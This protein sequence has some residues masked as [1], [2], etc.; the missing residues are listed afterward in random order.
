MSAPKGHG[1]ADDAADYEDLPEPEEPG[2][3]AGGIAD[4]ANLFEDLVEETSDGGRSLESNWLYQVDGHVFGPV[5]PK[6][7]L[8]ML[9][10]GELTADSPIAV[11]DEEFSPLRRFGVFRA[12]LPKVQAHQQELENQKK[13]ERAET[14]RRVMRRIGMVVA[15]VLVLAG[16]S[17]GLMEYI[18]W[19]REQAA[20][21]EKKKKEEALKK[22]IDDLYAS[23]TIE[24]PLMPL[25]EETDEPRGKGKGK[26][27]RR[28]RRGK[29]A[30]ASFGTGELKREEIMGGVAKVF[31]GF[32]R[33]IVEQM[34]REPDTVPE[35]IVLTFVIGNDGKARDVSITD[36]IL[37]RSPLKGCMAGQ[38]GRTRWRAFKGEVRNVEYPIT[39]GRR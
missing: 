3:K 38:L 9:Y 5:K 29:R 12:H 35:Q 1:I 19:S 37:R 8:Q 22:Q 24:P 39:I 28:R 15:A 4:D 2:R 27:K 36:R 18:R 32:K 33:C 10:D 26:R 6:E 31:G 23:V 13:K 30:V 14:K 17:Y 7:I 20:L 11:E 34:Q 25:V 21:A 16:G